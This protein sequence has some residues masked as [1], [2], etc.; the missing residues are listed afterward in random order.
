[1]KSTKCILFL[2]FLLLFIGSCNKKPN[3]NE[4]IIRAWTGK[5]MMIPDTIHY[6]ILGQ[7]TICSDLWDRPYK[8]LT[9]VDSIGCTGCQLDLYSWKLLMDS[10]F[11]VQPHIGLLF[12]VCSSDYDFF[13]QAL[14][15]Y[16]FNYPI[17]YDRQNLFDQLNHF[18][19]KPFRTFLLDKNNKVLLVGSPI[20]SP[21]MWNL[22]KKMLTRVH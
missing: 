17:I 11:E 4:Q 13:E 19:P 16:E 7:D 3:A 21:K 8:I 9:Y 20:N 5:E 6:K 12:V 15:D 10:C 2:S 14:A 18:P 22:Y 1:M